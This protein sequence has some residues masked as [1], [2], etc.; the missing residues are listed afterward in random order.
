[1]DYFFF[2]WVGGV[3]LISGRGHSNGLQRP[4]RV[5]ISGPTS[6]VTVLKGYRFSR[7]RFVPNQLAACQVVAAGKKL[8]LKKKQKNKKAKE[9]LLEKKYQEVVTSLAYY[10]SISSVAGEVLSEVDGTKNSREF[11]LYLR[12]AFARVQSNTT[13]VRSFPPASAK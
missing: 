10:I 3:G 6:F 9:D 11:W 1:M 13:A 5:D 12:M 8:Q 7:S 4:N 2:R